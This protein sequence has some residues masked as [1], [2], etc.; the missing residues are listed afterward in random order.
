MRRGSG[1]GEIRGLLEGEEIVTGSTREALDGEREELE[2]L[3][4]VGEGVGEHT[5]VFGT[6]THGGGGEER[7]EAVESGLLPEVVVPFP[8]E[9]GVDMVV[10]FVLLGGE[11]CVGGGIPCGDERMEMGGVIVIRPEKETVGMES[12][13]EVEAGICNLLHGERERGD[14]DAVTSIGVAFGDSPDTEEA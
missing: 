6:D 3:H 1:D 13:V 10:G 11:E 8:K 12:G 4:D 14:E 9:V 7:C 2:A 5:E